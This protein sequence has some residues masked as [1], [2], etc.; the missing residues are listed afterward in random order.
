MKGESLTVQTHVV[1]GEDGRPAGGSCAVQGHVENTVRGLDTVLLETA[2]RKHAFLKV[3][4]DP[5]AGKPSEYK[6]LSLI[7]L[8]NQF[9]NSYDVLRQFFRA[10]VVPS[11]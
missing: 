3:W 8:N 1:E 4:F 2:R 6:I 9:P 11:T 5:E 10:S 7:Y